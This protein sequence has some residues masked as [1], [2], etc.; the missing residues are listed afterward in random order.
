MKLEHVCTVCPLGCHIVVE[1]SEV[2]G[3]QCERG[4]NYIMDE[5]I[6]PKRSISSTVRITGST[7]RRLPVKTNIPIP[8]DLIIQA[9]EQLN[10]IEVT[11]PI[12]MG[13]VV[14]A[15]VLETDASFVA[16]RSMKR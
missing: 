5:I 12:A 11:A 9:V 1:D 2:S 14:L 6:A 13:D 16:S 7:H 8:K 4:Y 3:N 10:A 15:K